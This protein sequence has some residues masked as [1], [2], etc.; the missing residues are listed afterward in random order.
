MNIDLSQ[1]TPQQ[2][3][4]LADEALAAEKADAQKRDNDRKTYKDMVSEKVESL[5][6]DLEHISKQ[7]SDAKMNIYDE[8]QTALELKAELYDVPADQNCHSFINKAANMRITL[9]A[10]IKDDYDDTVNEGIKKVKVFIS[11][12]VKDKDSQLLVTSILKLLS[13]DQKGNL[14]ASKVMQLRQMAEQSGNETF[15]DGV[16]IIEQAYR[17]VQTKTFVRA[18]R[19]NDVRAWVQVPLGMTES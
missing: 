17:P 13:R 14:K 3:K 6:P 19:K 11:S 16:K 12:L 5:F 18:E 2:R 1:L 7:L 10:C 9:G 8:F 4:A 15:L